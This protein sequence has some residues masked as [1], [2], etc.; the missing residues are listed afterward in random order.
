MVS[1]DAVD[2]SA[3]SHVHRGQPLLL[4]DEELDARRTVPAASVLAIANRRRRIDT[5]G[6]I[7]TKRFMN[8]ILLLML[9]L[10]R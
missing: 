1:S 2:G 8:N 3:S 10:G 9:V 6:F 5:S 4:T 7:I